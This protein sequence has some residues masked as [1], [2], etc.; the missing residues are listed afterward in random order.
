MDEAHF[1]SDI[2]TIE[3]ERTKPPDEVVCFLDLHKL[4]V[5]ADRPW[6]AP[7]RRKIERPYG[8]ILQILTH[9]QINPSFFLPDQA[10]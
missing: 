2:G 9:Q 3:K 8:V 1:L 4:T 5:L 6:Q 10:T 7:R